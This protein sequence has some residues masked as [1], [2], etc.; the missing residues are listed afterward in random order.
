MRVTRHVFDARLTAD[1]A[2]QLAAALREGG[3]HDVVC[4]GCP[5]EWL[6]LP[7]P[8]RRMGD[9]GP[10][11]C[12]LAGL[13]KPADTSPSPDAIHAWGPSV[14][15]YCSHAA[16]RAKSPLVLHLSAA[17]QAHGLKLSDV[18]TKLTGLLYVTVPAE[19]S[20]QA[21]LAD[22][23]PADA[24]SV[25]PPAMVP[26]GGDRQ[27]VRERLGLS[28]DMKLIVAPDE[29]IRQAGLKYAI[30]AYVVLRQ[31]KDS[32]RL[33]LPVGGPGEASLRNFAETTWYLQEL[34]FPRQ[35]VGLG[36]ALVAA[37]V[38]VFPREQ[39]TGLTAAASARAAGVPIVATTTPDLQACLGGD[40]LYAAPKDPRRL[41]M[42]MLKLLEGR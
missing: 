34:I 23:L 4:V 12:L 38:A 1:A 27:A 18:R 6:R 20:R 41:A 29:M 30:W 5:P 35:D 31:L 9:R 40:A 11:S 14:L 24:V 8:V 7:V 17:A 16:R 39:D 25:L 28:P 13:R 10:L 42:A 3:P 37:D 19:P 21:L 33:M 36:D 22:G 2:R 26:L 32:I 15:D